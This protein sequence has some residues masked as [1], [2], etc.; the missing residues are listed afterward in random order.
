VLSFIQ[1]DLA[2]GDSQVDDIVEMVIVGDLQDGDSQ[3]D[4]SLFIAKNLSADLIN[5]KV[6]LC[7][8]EADA[9][10]GDLSYDDAL[11]STYNY[12]YSELQGTGLETHHLI[13]KRLLPALQSAFPNANLTEGTII[14]TPLNPEVHQV[15]TN[16]WRNF[17]PY[18]D[19]GSYRID[20]VILA[21]QE[22]YKNDPVMLNA[23]GD[24]LRSLGATIS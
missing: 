14:S 5:K 15:Y 23:A 18:V 17:L 12:M 22:V 3:L 6:V 24:W 16:A 13:K 19:S 11:Y 20:Q 21:V 7:F 8:V 9:E 2:D 10:D 4:D 1:L